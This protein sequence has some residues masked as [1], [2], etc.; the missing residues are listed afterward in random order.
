MIAIFAFR[1]FFAFLS[2]FSFFAFLSFLSF[3]AYK[4]PLLDATRFPPRPP[5]LW[6][7]ART[8]W[9]VCRTSRGGRAVLLWAPRRTLMGTPPY[10]LPRLTMLPDPYPRGRWAHR[11]TLMGA[12]P[13]SYGCTAVPRGDTGSA[14]FGFLNGFGLSGFSNYPVNLFYPG[15]EGNLANLS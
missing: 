7:P 5:A 11:R 9:P 14:Q 12:H 6:E 15:S 10:L 4:L 1:S 3:F 2:F 8:L 13:Y